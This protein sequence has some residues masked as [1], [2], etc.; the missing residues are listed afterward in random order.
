VWPCA[1]DE[2]PWTTQTLIKEENMSDPQ[3]HVSVDVGCKT[4]RVGIA[5]SEG[6]ILE[7]FTIPHSQ[8]GFQKFF[9]H[10][11]GYRK[12]ANLSVVVAMEGYN[13]HARPLDRMIQEKGYLLLN[14]NNLKLA[15]F[16]EIF[17]GAAKSDS[18][19]TRKILE[20]FHLK[21]YLPLAR[22]VLQEIPRTPEENEKLKRLSRRR[23][24]LVE[25]KVRLVNRMQD[26]LHAVCPEL[27]SLTGS[28]DNLW[29][30][31][32]LSAKDDLR[33]LREMSQE[34]LLAIPGIGRKFGSLIRRWQKQA[35]FSSSVEYVGPMIISDARRILEL[36]EEIALLEK[37][38]EGLIQESELARI[39]HSIPG[40]GKVSAAELAGE[41][42]TLKRFNSEKS[43]ALYLG[44]C[45]LSYQSG[46][47]QGTRRPR[48]VN[49][50]GKGAM[51]TAVARH[52]EQVPESRAYYEKK[53]K[54]GKKH[55]Q[56]IRSLGRHLVRVIWSML[57]ERRSYRMREGVGVT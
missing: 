54:E 18:L 4:H 13:G 47:F 46:Q 25:E 52:M 29:F 32:F 3:I 43:L 51:M 40:F 12:G 38:L 41:I 42:G 35:K 48:Q 44:M 39:L 55:N 50:R 45:P 9:D 31:R 56:A 53:R 21:D 20:L 34:N 57:K 5:S 26:D 24:Q 15:R 33:E 8:E 22:D 49:W 19:D 1:V 16:R 14:M 2:T 36:R 10:I 30:L 6:K 28:T 17:P 37:S 11:E 27:L 23:R 7:E